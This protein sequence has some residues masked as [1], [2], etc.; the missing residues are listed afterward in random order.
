M[1]SYVATLTTDEDFQPVGI[2]S[3]TYA[4]WI[5]AIEANDQL[6]QRMAFALSQILVTSNFGGDLLTD[7]PALV[8]Y[9]MDNLTTHA[10]GNYRDLLGDVTYS[11]V[12]AHYLTYLDNKKADPATGRMPDENYARE[13]L[14]LFTIGLVELNPDGT[15][16]TD[17]SGHPVELYDNT[18]ITG[19][20]RVFTGLTLD[21]A[22]EVGD[23]FT[24]VFTNPL[25]VNEEFHSE[26]EKSFLGLTIPANTNAEDSIEQALDHIMAHPNVGP[27]IGRQLI[28]RFTTSDPDPDY[29]E[30]VAAA[31]DAG[32]FTL[33][34]GT[35]IGDGRKGDLA[36]T[37]AAILFDPD[38]QIDAAFADDRF[39]K[40]REPVIRIANWAQAFDVDASRPELVEQ[41]MDT[42]EPSTLN[43]HP[44]RAR[45]VFN[46]YRPGY[47][48]PGTNTGSLGMTVP[49]LQI[50]NATSTP[51]YLNILTAFALG[52]EIDIDGLDEL[53][54][55]ST[56]TSNGAE[57]MFVADYTTELNLAND[58]TALVDHLDNLLA[59]GSLQENTKAE[60]ITA[61][62]GVP[63]EGGE[64]FDGPSTRV[65]IAVLL[66]MSTPEYLVQR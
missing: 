14:Q 24:P 51:G 40:V 30:R 17:G 41:L 29:V 57:R 54:A 18:D 42:S 53:L 59:Y 48:A 31:F 34:D 45:S 65:G 11:P 16:V 36:A 5:N 32:R 33:P 50:I 43:Q 25:A 28:Q 62:E 21:Y 7:E 35:L 23:D 44:Y 39:G 55:D 19:L 61:V 46:F 27:F 2:N 20:A 64:N 52:R 9:H 38:N 10:F 22:R 26:R 47:V 66:T 13:I 56:L 12:M 63:I 1:Q 6:R 37:L 8:A 49:E 3:T 4:F 15:P 58:P 60:I